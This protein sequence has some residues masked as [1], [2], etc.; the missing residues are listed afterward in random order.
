[1]ADVEEINI[2]WK[3][4]LVFRMVKKDTWKIVVDH[5]LSRPKK[6]PSAAYKRLRR[7]HIR[8]RAMV[9]RR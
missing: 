6:K 1:M 5:L 7:L 3:D 8:S 9:A 4:R 2:Y